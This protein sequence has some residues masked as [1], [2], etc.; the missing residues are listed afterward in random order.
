MTQKT[1]TNPIFY[2]TK[3]TIFYLHTNT[4]Y[5]K[6]KHTQ[7]TY[8]IAEKEMTTIE[9]EEETKKKKKKEEEEESH[10]KER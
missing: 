10:K 5:D 4:N 8:I 2:T 1:N 9:E 7:N 3:D 6:K